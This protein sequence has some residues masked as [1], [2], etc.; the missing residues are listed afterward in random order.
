[1]KSLEEIIKDAEKKAQLEAEKLSAQ[2]QQSVKNA[3]KIEGPGLSADTA[4]AIIKKVT[5]NFAKE[6]QKKPRKAKKQKSTTKE[7]KEKA[8]IK[9]HFR[10]TFEEVLRTYEETGLKPFKAEYWFYEDRR[11]C[12]LIQVS[13]LSDDRT[14]ATP[15]AAYALLKREQLLQSPNPPT[16]ITNYRDLDKLSNT[17]TKGRLSQIT[18]LSIS[19]ILGFRSGFD[20]NKP[21]HPNCSKLY[22]LGY[23]DGLGV[24]SKM[25]EQKLIEPDPSE[26]IYA[27]ETDKD[28][29]FE[30]FRVRG[31]QQEE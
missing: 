6:S 1:V 18:G 14:C 29:L 2:I 16:F 20:G 8:Q 24:R 3:V 5:E 12:P 11:F 15:M 25:M 31:Y 23:E 13:I 27:G 30:L 28:V 26:D 19:Y 4:E 7:A 10:L 21:G 17:W 9:K 22:H